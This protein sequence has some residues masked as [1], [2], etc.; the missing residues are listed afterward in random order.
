MVSED[1]TLRRI[2]VVAPN[3]TMLVLVVEGS[4]FT[5]VEG[6]EVIEEVPIDAIVAIEEAPDNAVPMATFG[7]KTGPQA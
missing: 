4:Y 6:N 5:G 1:V 7:W 2:P 3:G